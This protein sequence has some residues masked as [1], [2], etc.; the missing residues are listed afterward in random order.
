MRLKEDNSSYRASGVRHKDARN[1]KD[2]IPEKKTTRKHN[3]KRW[4]KGKVGVLHDIGPWAKA[5][6]RF[7]IERREKRCKKCNRV[8]DYSYK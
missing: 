7:G 8:M 6:V 3:R 4:C 2:E 5:I 1:A